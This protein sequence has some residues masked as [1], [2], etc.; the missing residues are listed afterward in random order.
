MK[1]IIVVALIKPQFEAGRDEVGKKGIVKDPKTHC[2]VLSKM[3][4][5]YAKS[6]GI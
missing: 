1:M 5:T 2:K 3:S 4:L 6:D